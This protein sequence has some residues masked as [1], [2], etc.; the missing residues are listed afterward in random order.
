MVYISRA[1]TGHFLQ[2]IQQFKVVLITGPR[3]VGKSTMLTTVMNGK[4]EYVSLDDL[5]ELDLAQ[6]DPAL[7]LKNHTVLKNERRAKSYRK[8]IQRES[9]TKNQRVPILIDEVQ[10]APQLFRQLKLV[11]DRSSA[12]GQFI[13]TGSQTYHL[14][15]NVSETLAGRICILQMHGLSLREMNGVSF[16]EPFS[17]NDDYIASRSKHLLPYNDLWQSIFRG[18]MPALA[19][20]SVDW[21]AF[22]RSYVQTYIERDVRQ[23]LNVKDAQ[24]FYKFMV[25]LAARTG[26]LF[27]ASSIAQDLGISVNTVQEWTSVLETSGII[28]FLQPFSNNISKRMIKTP[29]MYFFDT[30]LVC[31][32]VGWSN[33]KAAQNGA[34]SGSLFETFVIAEILKS[35]Y[36]CGKDVRNLFYYRDK[37]KKEIDL[38]LVEDNVMYPVEIKKTAR[39]NLQMAV[40]FSVLNKFTNLKIGTGCIVCQIDKKLYLA[41]NV[42]VLPVEYI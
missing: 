30:G 6:N 11:V 22:Y 4:V 33:A 8:S 3:Q 24:I 26:Q 23:L 20:G 29:K 35:Y 37:D 5:N 9:T 21:N 25:G 41:E 7:F 39:P 27:N 17:V 40:D 14:M 19:D 16:S 28:H 18:S 15:K 42:V 36:S 32:L 12:K 31:Y 13:L 10:Y 34:M 1:I 2:M 38:L